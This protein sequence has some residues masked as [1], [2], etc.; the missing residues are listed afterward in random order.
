MGVYV[1][2]FFLMIINFY[3]GRK[4]LNSCSRGLAHVKYN[5]WLDPI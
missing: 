2:G 4:L 5:F 3:I 1:F